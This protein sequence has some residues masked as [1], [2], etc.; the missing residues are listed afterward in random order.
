MFIFKLLFLNFPLLRCSGYTD[1]GPSH[2]WLTTLVQKMCRLSHTIT[3]AHRK[4]LA[5]CFAVATL[6]PDF[7]AGLDAR[8]FLASQQN[9]DR[10]PCFAADNVYASASVPLGCAY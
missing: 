10:R 7:D 5:H 1:N 9:A 2:R 8:A 6:A 4:I 3:L